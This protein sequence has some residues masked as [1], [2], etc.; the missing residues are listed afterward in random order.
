MSTAE[1]Y[2]VVNVPHVYFVKMEEECNVI[3]WY[4]EL[5]PLHVSLLA[6]VYSTTHFF[7]D[8]YGK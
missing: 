7:N 4:A 3:C 2:L 8:S 6:L 5:F 1:I